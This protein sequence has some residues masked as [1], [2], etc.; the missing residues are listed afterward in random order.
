MANARAERDRLQAVT[1]AMQTRM[2]TVIAAGPSTPSATRVG[3]I[4]AQIAGIQKKIDDASDESA[5]QQRQMVCEKYG[6]GLNPNCS[7]KSG[8]GN[9]YATAR[10]LEAQSDTQIR[11]YQTQIA[12]LVTQREQAQSQVEREASDATGTFTGMI[13]S[14]RSQLDAAVAA[15]NA[16]QQKYDALNDGRDAAVAAYVTVLKASPDFKPISFGMASQFRALGVLYTSYGIQ[17]EKFM[18]KFL[19]M[20]IELTPVLQKLF[21]SPK[22]LYALKLDSGRKLESYEQIEHASA[23]RKQHLNALDDDARNDRSDVKSVARLRRDNV[24][25]FAAS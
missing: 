13:A 1:A 17:L 9:W 3:E 20:L 22:T 12:G 15:R 23:A 25:D 11:D 6:T 18:V 4:T 16:G 8:Q 2:D 24:R 19:I 10:E 14:V 5:R 21:L 7:G